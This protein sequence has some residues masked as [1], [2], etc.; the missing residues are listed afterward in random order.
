MKSKSPGTSLQVDGS[1]HIGE[2]VDLGV[3]WTC[4]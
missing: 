3:E 4:V 1:K 2:D